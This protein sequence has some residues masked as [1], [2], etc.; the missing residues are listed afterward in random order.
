MFRRNL[1]KGFRREWKWIKMADGRKIIFKKSK[2]DENSF[3]S[4]LV[5]TLGIKSPPFCPFLTYTLYFL[6]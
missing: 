2:G 5:V 3:R 1:V 6:W 4:P